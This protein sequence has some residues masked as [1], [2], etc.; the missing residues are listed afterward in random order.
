MIF[1]IV[2][3]CITQLYI[4]IFKWKY[5][6]HPCTVQDKFLFIDNKAYFNSV[7]IGLNEN[8]R[9]QWELL[10]KLHNVKLHV[11]VL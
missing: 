9:L 4:M 8:N 3:L 11:C 1:Y 10:I 6:M 7:I 2:S 5:I